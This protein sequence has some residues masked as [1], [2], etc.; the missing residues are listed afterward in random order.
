MKIL[1]RYLLKDNLISFVICILTFSA[2]IIVI[3]LFNRLDEILKFRPPLSLL[4]SF[5]LYFIP[6]TFVQT[7]PMALL[8][9]CLYSVGLLNK[10]HEITAMRASG[11]SVVRILVPFLFVGTLVGFLSF[12]ANETVVPTAMVKTTMI[13]EEKL[14]TKSEPSKKLLKNVALFSEEGDLYYASSYEATRHILHN[15]VILRDDE[16]HRPVFKIQAQEGRWGKGNWILSRGSKYRLDTKGKMVG[17]PVF[18]AKEKFPSSVKP[19]DILK[20]KRRGEAMSFQELRAHL[21][22]LEGRASPAVMRRHLVELHKK[23]A[24]PFAN[25]ITIL[26]GFPFIFREKRTGGMLKGIGVTA[27][28]CFSFH[29]TFVI[30]TNLGVQGVLPPWLA[31]WCANVVFGMGGILF[32]WRER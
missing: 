6:F 17:E 11:L 18:F 25:L 30:T 16:H 26:I 15:L 29:T 12:V 23:I 28:L 2:M 7:S 14:K 9:A 10:H 22:K 3:D 4:F 24:Y 27:I 31:V 19:D 21:K 13:K 32:L 1:D 20:A 8:V 5:Y